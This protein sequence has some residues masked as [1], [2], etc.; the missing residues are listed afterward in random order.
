[1]QFSII[2]IRD[3]TFQ[4]CRA[5]NYNDGEYR[6]FPIKYNM[7]FICTVGAGYSSSNAAE[8][9]S[10]YF[11]PDDNEPEFEGYETITYLNNSG[12][13]GVWVHVISLGY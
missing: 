1:M 10:A 2:F 3:I 12:S 4:W 11:L 13:G 6:T 5:I 7:G 9:A 8:Q